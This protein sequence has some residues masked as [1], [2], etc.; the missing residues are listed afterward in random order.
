MTLNINKLQIGKKK[1]M[2]YNTLQTRSFVLS[3]T[4]KFFVTRNCLKK[5]LHREENLQCKTKKLRNFEKFVKLITFV[6]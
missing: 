1:N 6:G 2:A 4:S 5:S 3:I